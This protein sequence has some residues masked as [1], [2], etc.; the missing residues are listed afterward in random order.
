MS[1][2]NQNRGGIIQIIIGTIFFLI[3]GQLVSLQVVSNKYKLAAD[4]NA[5]FRKIIYPDRGII[6]DR[7]K[8][9]LLENTISYDLVVIPNEAKG[10]DTAALCDILK[11]DKAEYS[12]R[13]IE[14]IIKNTRVKAGVFEPFLTPEIYAQL[15]ENLYRFPGF[16]LSERSIR[17]YPYNT[18]AHV[19]GYVAEVDVNFLKKHESEGYE[20]GDYAGMT[21]LE[22]NYEAVLMGQRGVKRFLRDNKGKIQGPYEKGE[23]DTIA[24]AGKNLYTSVDV[25]VQQLAEKLLQNKIGSAVAI[26]PKTGGV[27][28]MASS[29][30]YNPNLLTGSQRRK[31]IGR[32]LLDTARPIYNRAIKGQYPP[33]STFKPL[34]ALIALDEGLIT[35][36]Y[37]YNCFG[38]YGACGDPRKCE[39]HNAGHAANLQLALAYS[40]NSYFLQVF[41]MAIDNPKYKSAKGGYL[42]WKSYMNAFGFGRKLGVDLPSENKANIPDTAQYNK[43]FGNPRYWN[44]C[45]ML[46]LGI[47]QD[48]MTATPLQLANSMAFIAND[49][50][51]YT[52]HFVDSIESET[53]QEAAQLAPF[54]TKQKVTKIPKEYFDVIKEGM[55]DVTVY[56][57]AAFIKV[58]GHDYCAKTG[59]A[60]N[61][62]GKNH[63]LFVCFA[64]KDNP[65]IAV[66][67]IVENAGYG[68]TWAGPIG[69]LLMEQ[70]LNDTL[71]TESQLKADNLAQVDLMPQAIKNWYVQH[72][73]SAYLTPIEY[74]NDELSDVWDMEMLA[75]GVVKTKT[76][77]TNPPTPLPNTDKTNKDSL[78]PNGDKKKKLNP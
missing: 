4:N 57:T 53:E 45:Y 3:V 42:K 48:R 40:C 44:S 11:I 7:K 20:M 50:Y 9:A 24:I 56:G 58:P 34:G 12:K 13:I 65:K 64:P 22:K 71:T 15:N 26:N 62:H 51:Y 55:H 2:Y 49:G 18:A 47:G 75:E 10:V 28:A 78:L 37:G 67:V 54:R 6:Y 8:R 63:S 17:N 29:P 52:P 61:P 36:N 73:K 41:R 33:G 74:N 70:Y 16:T 31:T 5:I 66:A 39:H 46:T 35:P 69:G 68:S 1:V 43:D 19:L 23:F 38:S 30:G 77:D 59:T 60:Q 32:L 27:I 72:N 76:T 14:A 21:G 25:Q